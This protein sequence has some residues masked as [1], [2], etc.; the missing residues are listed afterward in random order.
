MSPRPA[1]FLDRDGVLIENRADYVR[2]LDQVIFIPGAAEALARFQRERPE[3]RVIIVSNQAGIGRGLIAPETVEAI[4]QIVLRHVAATGGRIDAVYVCPHHAD[5]GCECR[6]PKPGMLLQAAREWEI[7]LSASAFVGDSATDVQAARAAGVRP[8][9]VQ[10]GL[11]ERLPH[12]QAAA[13]LYHAS[14]HASLVEAMAQIL[15]GTH[16]NAP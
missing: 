6:K 1:L 15:N 12:E 10:T 3:W 2:S 16:I 8:I 7:D 9:F 13:Q 11:A 14:V 4:N 5:A